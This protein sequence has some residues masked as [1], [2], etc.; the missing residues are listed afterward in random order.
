MAS[1]Q[2][3]ITMPSAE[4]EVNT[5]F[6]ADGFLCLYWEGSDVG[7]AHNVG[8]DSGSRHFR[9]GAIALDEHRCIVALGGE[10]NDVV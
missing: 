4:N 10:A 5:S 6:S 9:S 7:H 8:K 2:Q 1:E 3:P